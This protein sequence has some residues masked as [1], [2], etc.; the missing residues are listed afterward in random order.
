VSQSNRRA[1]P[2]VVDQPEP[3]FFKLRLYAKGWHE[4]P[5]AIYFE[6]DQW[7]AEIDGKPAGTP[8]PDPVH[9][10]GV[11][12]VWHSRKE[13]ISPEEYEFLTTRLKAWAREYYPDHP[14]LDPMRPVV[15]GALRPIPKFTAPP[16]RPELAP[17]P[18][19]ENRPS[20]PK[21]LTPA[22]ITRFLDYDQEVLIKA[23]GQDVEQLALDAGTAIDNSAELSRIG[24]NMQVA[25][26]HARQ[27]EAAR[28]KAK[29]PFLDGGN[30]VDGY[31]RKHS[32]VLTGAI[33]PVQ[34]Q[35]DA[36]G[37][38]IEAERRQQAEEAARVAREEADRRAR[39]AAAAMAREQAE[40]EQ[41]ARI[42]G[43]D[44]SMPV[45][46]VTD[47]LLSEAEEAAKVADR[48]ER[49]AT[50]TAAEL[51]R[52]HTAYGGVMSTS[53]VWDWEI[54]DISEVPLEYLQINEQLVNRAVRAFTRDSVE[55]ARQ[56]GTPIR[57][58]R[59]TRSVTMR[60][61]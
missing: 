3:G 2:V 20:L 41:M 37:R 34:R 40:R 39:E 57:G 22:E 9:A 32:A 38:R 21:P 33:A 59:L 14:M 58:I 31:F 56:G 5:C 27:W 13:V 8:N 11:L 45:S 43:P 30:T 17:E 7:W 49:L 47:V 46:P 36:Y 26:D 54:E 44:A 10:D 25:R 4:V 35:M 52:E 12:R 18:L 42:L 1:R 61:R 50:G 28:V 23:I 15:A 55:K 29:K 24:A 19:P 16:P 60:N 51:T 6:N 48:E 53:E